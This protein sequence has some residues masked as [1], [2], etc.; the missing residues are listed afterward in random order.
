MYNHIS[1]TS[2][3]ISNR[4]FFAG[5]VVTAIVSVVAIGFLLA[6]FAG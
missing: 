1:N 5:S 3:D 4:E 6:R 2:Y